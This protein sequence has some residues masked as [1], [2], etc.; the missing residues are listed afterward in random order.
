MA[1]LK[2]LLDVLKSFLKTNTTKLKHIK[3][4]TYSI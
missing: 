3:A 2:A 4:L 1:R